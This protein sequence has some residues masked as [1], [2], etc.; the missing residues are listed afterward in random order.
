MNSILYINGCVRSASR[1]DRLARAVLA[2]IEG[3][4]EEIRLCD[5]DIRPLDE[6]RLARRD[7]LTGAGDYSD[8]MFD[9]ARRFKEADIIVMSAPYWDLQFPALIKIFIENITVTGLTFKYTEEGYPKGLCRARKLI[10]VTTSG[11]SIGPYDFGYEYIRTLAEGMF[12]IEEVVSYRAENLDIVGND[13]EQILAGTIAE[14][15]SEEE[16]R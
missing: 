13:P 16:N 2:K 9:L 1:T 15:N 6:E 3:K 14:I 12:G 10:Y 5:A 4:T 11:G 7:E 8:E